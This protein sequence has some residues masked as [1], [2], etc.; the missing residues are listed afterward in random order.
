MPDTEQKFSKGFSQSTSL[1]TPLSS[2]KGLLRCSLGCLRV[3]AWVLV[4]QK[5][6]RMSEELVRNCSR[7]GGISEPSC[8]W[9]YLFIYSHLLA[10]FCSYVLM[11]L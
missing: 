11:F 1:R 3:I 10:V 5:S 8:F 2:N 6:I 9:V 4:Q 7:S